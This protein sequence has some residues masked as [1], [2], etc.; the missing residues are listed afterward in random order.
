MK[1]LRRL[2]KDHII[3]KLFFSALTAYL[4]YEE[5]YVF[6]VEKPTYTSSAKLTIGKYRIFDIPFLP[7]I[8][9]LEPEDYPDITLCPFPSYNQ[10]KLE[11]YG[12]GQSFEYAK[13]CFYQYHQTSLILSVNLGQLR[14]VPSPWME[15]EQL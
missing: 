2:W 6:F 15:W 14:R 4:L 7:S 8:F 9:L 10:P 5:F 11:S 12:Y 1:Y 3:L 13:A